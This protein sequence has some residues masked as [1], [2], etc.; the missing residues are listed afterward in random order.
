M[1]IGRKL[2]RT[3]KSF[4]ER[5]QLF[6]AATAGAAGRVNLSPKGMDTLQDSR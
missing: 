4:I 1:A 5:Q 2:N 3:L 6:F